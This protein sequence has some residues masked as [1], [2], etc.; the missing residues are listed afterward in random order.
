MDDEIIGPGGTVC[1]HVVAGSAV[2]FVYMTDGRSGDPDVLA[3]N[4]SAAEIEQKTLA[5]AEQRKLESRTA[6][7]IVGVNDLVFLDGKDGGLFESPAIVEALAKLLAEKR[8]SVIYAPALTDHHRDH[9]ATN[10]ILH[11]ALQKL[12]PAARESLTIRGYEVWTPAPANAMVNITEMAASKKQAIEAF[13]TQTKFVDYSWTA[14]GLNQYRSMVHM[15]GRGYAE[16]F[17]EMTWAEYS[18]AFELIL[19]ARKAEV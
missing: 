6:A 8:P 10:R 15:H 3:Q 4:L 19:L 13:T 11:L 17:F 1:R 7:N 12:R 2:T 5:L 9:W 16:A 14:M 18:R